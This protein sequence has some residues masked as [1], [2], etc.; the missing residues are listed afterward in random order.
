MFG[1][2]IWQSASFLAPSPLKI[3]SF[4]A[5]RIL[6]CELEE[7][8]GS[9]RAKGFVAGFAQRL[10]K[11]RIGAFKNTPPGVFLDSGKEI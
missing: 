5:A 11:L 4:T 9:I 8:P 10:L 3:L 6:V 7:R 1:E 2:K